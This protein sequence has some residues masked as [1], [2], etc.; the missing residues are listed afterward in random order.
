M[1][2]RPSAR[3]LVAIVLL[4]AGCASVDT[5]VGAMTA[6]DLRARTGA[7]NRI[8]GTETPT[9]PATLDDGLSRDDA[10]ALALWNNPAFQAATSQLG[11]ARAD[12]VEAGLLANPT[13]SLLFPVGPKQLEATL[14]WPVEVLWERPKRVAAARLVLEA[15]ARTLVQSGLDLVLAVRIAFV[16]LELVSDRLVLAQE[17][18]AALARI[19]TLAGTRL[20]AGDVG[21]LDARAAQVDARRS[22]QD[23]ERL[24]YDVAVARERLRLLLGLSADDPAVLT[25]QRTS[26]SSVECG[27]ESTMVARGLAGRPDARAAELAVEGAAA[28]LG[29]ERRRILAL[30][31]VLDANG[32]G[33]RG[34]EAGPGIDASVP[35]FNR[36]QAGRLRA[37]A[38][39]QRVSAAYVAVQRQV[40]YDVREAAAQLAQAVESQGV[41]DRDILTPLTANLADAEESYTAGETSYL[42]VLENTRRLIDARLR[43]REIAADSER[44]RARLERAMGTNCE[45]STK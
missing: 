27:P 44:A 13:L 34:F 26:P 43:A 18:A 21:E 22:A 20:L 25:L 11:F 30:T 3:C 31:A 10:V 14:R 1:S 37:E 45:G 4:S 35:L 7:P 16:D 2:V 32:Q 36:N 41:W 15:A 24:T 8:A 6:E 9:A 38:E 23:A 42:F 12:L 19:A 5:R 28:R 17:S 39:L 29:W 40:A 33:T